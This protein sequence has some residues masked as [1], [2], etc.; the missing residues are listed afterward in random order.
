MVDEKLERRLREQLAAEAAT[1]ADRAIPVV[2]QCLGSG[3]EGEQAAPAGAP[4]DSTHLAFHRLRERLAEL[5]VSGEIREVPLSNALE[6]RLAP[7]QIRALAAHPAVGRIILSRRPAGDLPAAAAPPSRAPRR[8]RLG[9]RGPDEMVAMLS[10]KVIGQSSA[11]RTI[12]PYVLMY[13]AGLAP[14]GRPV[15]VSLL[16]G[17]TGTGKTRTVEALAETLHGSDRMLL[18]ID[19]SEFQEDHEVAKLIGAPPGYVGHRDTVPRLTQHRLGEVTSDGCDLSIVLFDEIEK[20]APSL[21]RLLLGVLDRATLRLGDGTSVNFEKSFIF[22]TSNLG[23]RDMMKEL[24]PGFGFAPALAR[25][26]GEL[27][28][29]LEAIALAAVRKAFSPEF[30]NRIDAVVTYEPLGEDALTAILAQQIEQL[31]QHVNTRLGPAGFT[32]EVPEEGRQFL[33]RRGASME[34]GARELA[35]TVHRHLTQ[36]LA[37]LVATGKV[38]P[39]SRVRAEP[40]ASGESLELRVEP[41]PSA[42]AGGHRILVV[43]D[44]RPLL[45]SLQDLLSRAGWEVT[46]AATARGALAAADAAAP[47]VALLDYLL[48]DD[49]G[50][51]LAVELKRRHPHIHIVVMS[52][53][54]LPAE[55]EAI[56]RR[57]GF[58]MLPKPF[59]PNDLLAVIQRA[60]AARAAGA[61]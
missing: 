24:A 40:A 46:G 61:G 54:G 42:P 43:D 19:C 60:D 53:L 36:P 48:P 59:R 58:L 20:A 56:C 12:V 10:E 8:Q 25:G 39:R 33:L 51:D 44:N 3:P 4:E 6:A 27:S 45:E 30:V 26:R 9:W 23:A 22:L 11:M 35:R 16:L 29:R 18:R 32:I 17:P 7:A 34:Y 2:I 5:G 52:G 21:T 1:G 31:Q 50:L 49:S 28:T 55:D 41:P 15:G 57:A 14:A 13:E 37:A 47:A 38:E